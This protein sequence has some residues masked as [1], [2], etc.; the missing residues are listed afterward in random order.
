MVKTDAFL[1]HDWGKDEFGRDNHTRVSAINDGL[2]A[3]GIVAWFDSDRMEGNI[4]EQMC[5]GVEN[6]NVIVVFNTQRYMGKVGSDNHNGS[7]FI[8]LETKVSEAHYSSGNGD[9]LLEFT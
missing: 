5:D 6:T 1:T 9:S 7:N 3:M 4:V 2:K 8:M